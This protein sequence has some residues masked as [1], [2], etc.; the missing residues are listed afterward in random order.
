[1]TEYMNMQNGQ[2]TAIEPR[3]EKCIEESSFD[4][5]LQELEGLPPYR[6]VDGGR[7]LFSRY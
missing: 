4:R 2:V 5:L 1:M 6:I 7:R 3:Q